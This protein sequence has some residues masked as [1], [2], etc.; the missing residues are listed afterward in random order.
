MARWQ[1]AI[2][3]QSRMLVAKGNA[4]LRVEDMMGVKRQDTGEPEPTGEVRLY[5]RRIYRIRKK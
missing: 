5:G 3:G 1:E 2:S 4:G